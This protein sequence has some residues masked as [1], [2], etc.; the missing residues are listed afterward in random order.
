[1]PTRIRLQRHGRKGI[2]FYHIVITDGRAPRD[3][4]FIEKIGT[5]NPLSKPADIQLDFDRA[6]YWLQEGA[7]PSDT[8]RALF[9][10]KGL[11]YKYHL[12]KGV[13]KNALT[14]EQAEER[15]NQWNEEK[16]SRLQSQIKD[17]ILKVKELNKARA[18]SES[19]VNE[20]RAA[21]LAKKYAKSAP[22]KPPDAEDT[23][24]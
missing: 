15:F 5:Y 8:A 12:L 13:K 14:L 23:A 21:A 3:G 10:S 7:Q 2:A 17:E 24:T 22:V 18:A 9:S 1:M 6:L 11:L 4:R 20:K 16:T 19:L